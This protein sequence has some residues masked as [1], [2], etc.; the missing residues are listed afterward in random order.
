MKEYRKEIYAIDDDEELSALFD[1]LEA[2][3]EEDETEAEE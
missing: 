1:E 2:E 3:D